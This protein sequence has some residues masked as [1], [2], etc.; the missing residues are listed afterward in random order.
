[1]IWHVRE[2]DKETIV[3]KGYQT[4]AFYHIRQ[5]LTTNKPFEQLENNFEL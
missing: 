4:H 2:A 1:M 3:Q 5:M